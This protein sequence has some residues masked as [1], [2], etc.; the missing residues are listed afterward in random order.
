MPEDRG[1]KN[2]NASRIAPGAS[3]TAPRLPGAPGVAL[4]SRTSVGSE[5]TGSA[6]IDCSTASTLAF[7]LRKLASDPTKRLKL[8]ILA[9]STPI[10]WQLLYIGDTSAGASDKPELKDPQ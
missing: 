1:R 3:P 6:A 2:G 8:Q 5:T 10:P 4:G 7:W 9:E